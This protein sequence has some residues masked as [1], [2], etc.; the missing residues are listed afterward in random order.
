M[1]HK[2]TLLLGAAGLLSLVGGGLFGP[3]LVQRLAPP[4]EFVGHASASE[5][6]VNIDEQT[7]SADLI[8][9]ARVVSLQN[10]I[11]TE[12]LPVYAEDAVTII[13]QREVSTPF[14]DVTLEVLETF[15]GKSGS[16]IV[17]LQTGGTMNSG[18]FGRLQKFSIA[19]DPLFEEGSEHILFLMD[20]TGDGVHST[21]RQLYR[22]VN[23]MGRYELRPEGTLQGPDHYERM[24]PG[25][26]TKLPRTE[27]DLR[28]Q[29]YLAMAGQDAH[30]THV[31]ASA[32][33]GGQGGMADGPAGTGAEAGSGGAEADSPM[34]GGRDSASAGC[35]FSMPD[36]SGSHLPLGVSIASLAAVLVARRR[37]RQR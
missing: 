27:P 31:L 19:A 16:H 3:I 26:V 32:G 15:K 18:R 20:I 23:P 2:R 6:A 28:E 37:R 7:R 5:P 8:V 12:A 21:G 14:T 13:D 4:V 9:R 10:R 35:A 33:T 22:V 17:A 30:P 34:M 11:L 29:I 36:S 25:I 24:A 1:N